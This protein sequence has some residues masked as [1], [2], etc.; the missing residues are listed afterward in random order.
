MDPEQLPLLRHPPTRFDVHP[1]D[2][3]GK[4]LISTKLIRKQFQSTWQ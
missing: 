3:H 4:A 2:V 1:D